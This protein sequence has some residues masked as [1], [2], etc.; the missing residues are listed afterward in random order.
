MVPSTPVVS[1]PLRIQTASLRIQTACYGIDDPFTSMIYL[2]RWL[3][4]E[5]FT[6]SIYFDDFPMKNILPKGIFHSKLFN[7]HTRDVIVPENCCEWDSLIWVKGKRLFCRYGLLYPH[8]ASK[9]WINWERSKFLWC[10]CSSLKIATVY[11]ANVGPMG[12]NP[13]IPISAYIGIICAMVK[14]R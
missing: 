12:F 10:V 4:Y 1:V 9:L 3:T 8:T 5:V 2:L 14:T 6:Y 11:D 7:Y 13:C